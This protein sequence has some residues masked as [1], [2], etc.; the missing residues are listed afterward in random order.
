MIRTIPG[1]VT[2]VPGFLASGIYCGIKKIKAPDLA[3][4]FSKEPCTAAGLFTTNR[5]TAPPVRLTQK[6]IQS[7]RLQV[8][9]ANS[10]NANACTGSYGETIARDMA[11][12][13]ARQCGIAPALVAVAST[14]VIGEPPPLEALRPGIPRAVK[15]LGPKGSKNAARAIMTTDLRPKETAARTI[16]G[17]RTVTVGGIAKGSG[18]IHPNMATMLAFLTTDISIEP[19]LLQQMLTDA[20]DRSFNMVT[21]DGATSTND[22]MI[23]LA[24]G[25]ARNPDLNKSPEARAI[26]Q[27]ALNTVCIALAKEIARDGEGAT[28]FVEIAV[29]RAESFK[30]AKAVAMNVAQSNLVKTAFFGEDANWG[31]IMAAIG[32]AGVEIDPDRIH[33]SFDRVRLVENS[34]SLGPAAERKATNVL[35][36]KT[37]ILTI[38]L[39]MGDA[40]ATAWTCDLSYDYIKINAS[41]RS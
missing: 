24:N 30:Q 18:M 20:A 13:T 40:N 9:V 39:N 6:H 31:R 5:V 23:C 3:L 25:K 21:V 4:I 15:A 32:A 33:L 26:F 7:G 29:Q 17:G 10:G 16:I 28:K 34:L 41:Y 14:G 35:K 1:G 8:I 27:E 38:D 2:A 19:P 22:M 11:E 36:K 37:F 12:L